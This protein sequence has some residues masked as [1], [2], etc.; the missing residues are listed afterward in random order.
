MELKDKITRLRKAMG[1]TQVEFAKKV[2]ITTRAV[3]NYEMGTRKPR[4]DLIVKIADIFDVDVK[5]LLADNENYTTEESGK[6]S[7]ENNE[8]SEKLIDYATAFFADRDISEEEKSKV[9]EVLQEAYWQYK[10]KNRKYI[11]KKNKN[12]NPADK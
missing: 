2:G 1:L 10:I 5:E 3:Q 9:M 7:T 6:P 12:E 8:R 4:V 11:P